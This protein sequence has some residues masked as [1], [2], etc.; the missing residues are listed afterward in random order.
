MN[1][2]IPILII[3][4]ILTFILLLCTSCNSSIE[5]PENSSPETEEKLTENTDFASKPNTEATESQNSTEDMD[6][7]NLM[8]EDFD[9]G[10]CKQLCGK[11]IVVLLYMDDFESTWTE[12]EITKF[13]EFEVNP[14][15]DFMEKQAQ[16]HNVSLSMEIGYI[17][18]GLYYDDEV[19]ESV[20]ETGYATGDV[21]WKASLG[22]GYA[23]DKK[24]LDEYRRQFQT[25]EIVC[26]AIFNKDGTSYALNPKRGY[27]D[28]NIREHCL[29]FAYDRGSNKQ[30]AIRGGQSSVIAHEMLHLF[31]AEDFYTPRA[32]KE[33]A[34]KKFSKDIMLHQE[35][36][37]HKNNIGDA[38]AFYIGWIDTV[39]EA[40]YDKN[41]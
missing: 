41:W 6:K 28:Y 26:F 33:I 27:D 36:E 9:L 25:E 34:E 19:I 17:H 35:Y 15:L 24:M 23:S 40:L 37:I 3:A 1:R 38:T 11:V 21:L 10:N 5:E 2:K 30:N 22:L 18:S 7:I 39:P 29:I 4:I 16:N 20:K 8:R 13:T 14:A 31:G 32:R 12:D